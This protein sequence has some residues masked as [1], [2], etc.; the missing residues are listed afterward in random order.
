V[1]AAT[2]FTVDAVL[3][4]RLYVLFGAPS[5]LEVMYT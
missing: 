1:L 5:Q 3:L 4:K 2:C